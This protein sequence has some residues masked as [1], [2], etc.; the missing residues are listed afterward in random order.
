MT[1]EIPGNELLHRQ[2]VTAASGQRR[3]ALLMK[4]LGGGG[5]Q[6]SMLQL[7]RG[8]VERGIALELLVCRPTGEF[9]K[10][11]PD[12]VPIVELPAT[13]PGSARLKVLAAAPADWRA[14]LLP[15]LVPPVSPWHL[16][17]LTALTER[18]REEPPD[19]LITSSSYLSL[20]ALW[21]RDAARA[22]TAVIVSERGNLTSHVSHGRRRFRLRLRHLP[23]L[24]RRVYPRADAIVAVSEGVARDLA[25]HAGIAHERIETIYNPVVTPELDALAKEQ[26]EHPWFGDGGAP[27]V[28]GAGRLVAQKG[29]QTLIDAVAQ[30]RR[31]R[32]LRLLVLG[33]G[34][35][36]AALE[37]RAARTGLGADFSL[38]GFTDN[39]FAFMSRASAFALSSA[40]EGLPGVL[41]QALACGCPV[42]STDCPDGPSEILEKGAYGPLVPVGDAAAL[43]RALGQVLDTPP[44]RERLRDRGRSFNLAASTDCWLAAIERAVEARAA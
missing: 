22:P 39:P 31:E 8:L 4:S 2:G 15:V 24:V 26:P 41:I 30:L 36:R 34:K 23:P 29:F 11:V 37:S 42:V 9:R 27:I 21:A 7:A 19:V 14:L 5:V 44:D 10:L 13:P 17:H 33:E 1:V 6:R 40:Y 43:A 32:P 38:P 20:A 25:A 35:Y 18:L 12:G 16:R 28:L 3:V